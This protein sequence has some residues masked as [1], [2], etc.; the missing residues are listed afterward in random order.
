M[1][2]VLSQI[3]EVISSLENKGYSVEADKLDAV[4]T[5]I[6]QDKSFMGKIQDFGREVGK[7]IKKIINPNPQPL[8]VGAPFTYFVKAGDTFDGVVNNLREKLAGRGQYVGLK[9]SF[10]DLVISMNPGL[11]PGSLVPGQA[12]NLPRATKNPNQ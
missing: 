6:A 3:N 9:Q 12:I 1:K 10:Q 8:A 7:G 11:N 2:T 4:F 5:K